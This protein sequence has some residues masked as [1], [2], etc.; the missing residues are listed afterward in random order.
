MTI[1]SMPY[2]DRVEDSAGHTAHSSL[3]LI[4]IGKRKLAGSNGGTRSGLV[5]IQRKLEQ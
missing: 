5:R 1:V 3:C 4:A 2:S